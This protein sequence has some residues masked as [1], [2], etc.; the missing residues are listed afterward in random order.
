LS[1][2]NGIISRGSVQFCKV[3]V[4]GRLLRF[5]PRPTLPYRSVRPSARTAWR[6]DRVRLPPPGKAIWAGA[7]GKW[8]RSSCAG[9]SGGPTRPRSLAF[10]RPPTSLPVVVALPL[11]SSSASCT[12]PLLAS[13]TWLPRSLASAIALHIV[14]SVFQFAFSDTV[15]RLSKSCLPYTRG[16]T[17]NV[18]PRLCSAAARRSYGLLVY[19]SRRSY[20]ARRRSRSLVSDRLPLGRLMRFSSTASP[21]SY[22]STPA[23]SYRSSLIGCA[24]GLMR[25]SST[26]SRRSY[27]ARRRSRIARPL[28][29]PNAPHA[30]CLALPSQVGE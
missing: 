29:L 19:A 14:P 23:I 11:S 16:S 13:A 12:S 7:L 25:F 5:A 26:A 30:I 17:G 6:G 15:V 10:R 3:V 28:M 24:R 27:V 4:R 9:C 1:L 18:A 20:V 21:E 8:S 22:V 2:Y